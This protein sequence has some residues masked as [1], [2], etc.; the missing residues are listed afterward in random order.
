MNNFGRDARGMEQSIGGVDRSRT[1]EAVGEIENTRFPLL[2]ALAL[3]MLAV[4]A[5]VVWLAYTQGVARG[6]R[7]T[8]ELSSQKGFKIYEQP[9]PTDGDVD[10]VVTPASPAPAVNPAPAVSAPLLT[11][12]KV[13]AEPSPAPPLPNAAAVV[14]RPPMALAT[15]ST[16]TISNYVLQ[17]GAYMSKSDAEAAWIAYRE[18]HAAL[19]ADASGDVQQADLGDKGIWWR[20]RIIGFPSKDLASAMCERLAADGGTCFVGK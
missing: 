9:A 15:R 4:F 3:L 16:P 11:A 7:E 6:Q 13:V 5:G 17:I 18:R 20:L 10:S 2:I 1:G 14:S 19:L 8:A 12:P